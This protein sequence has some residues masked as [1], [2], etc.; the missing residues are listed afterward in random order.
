MTGLS[1]L[2][3]LTLS[4]EE[5]LIVRCLTLQPGSTLGEIAQIVHLSVQELEVH[6]KSL[7]Q[8]SRLVEQLR[9]G[10]RIFSVRFKR[11]RQRIRNIPP[12]ALDLFE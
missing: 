6:I 7:L 10:Q 2:E 11:E 12:S 4:E 3:L 8:E 5:Q 9:D 1:A